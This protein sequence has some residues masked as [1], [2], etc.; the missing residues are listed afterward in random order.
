MRTLVAYASTEG[1]TEKMACFIMDHLA[2]LGYDAQLVNLR[3]PAESYA[4]QD[5]GRIILAG[6]VHIGRLQPELVAFAKAN[7]DA[8]AGKPLALLV[9][10]L[11]AAGDRAADMK[12]L[13]KIATTFCQ[14]TGL[15]PLEVWQEA[16]AFRF[17]RYGLVTSIVMW[18]IGA[19]H[20]QAVDPRK[21][22]EYTN[23]DRLAQRVDGFLART[24]EGGEQA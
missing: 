18:L 15:E 23:W 20:G 13:G 16:G 14:N 7:A 6:S 4:V 19:A 22:S 24:D 10:S 17:S 1:Q 12:T 2:S 8:L 21:D 5:F 3:S 11:A 9:N